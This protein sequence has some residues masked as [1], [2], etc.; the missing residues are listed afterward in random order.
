MIKFTNLSQLSLELEN[1]KVK[2]EIT[3]VISGQEEKINANKINGQELNI[4]EL[5]EDMVRQ[6]KPIKQIVS[7]LSSS[8]GLSKNLLYKKAPEIKKR[9]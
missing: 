9:S 7:E 6:G 1:E 5:L 2:G 4:D 8:T 3:L